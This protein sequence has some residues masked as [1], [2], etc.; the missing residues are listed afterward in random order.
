MNGDPIGITKCIALVAHDNKKMDLLE[1]ARF[2]RGH[3]EHVII[4]S[5]QAP[6]EKC[7]RNNSI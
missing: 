1:W 2:Q 4:S 3:P 5:P 7:W 6:L